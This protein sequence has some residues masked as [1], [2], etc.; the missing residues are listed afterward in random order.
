LNQAHFLR[1]TPAY[2]KSSE[3]SVF[4]A[5]VD[6]Q[7]EEEVDNKSDDDNDE[8]PLVVI[9]DKDEAQAAALKMPAANHKHEL[10]N[11]ALEA[12]EKAPH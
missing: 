9:K 8:D 5:A 2:P 7:K 3:P 12:C 11:A 10:A 4:E 1:C 6:E